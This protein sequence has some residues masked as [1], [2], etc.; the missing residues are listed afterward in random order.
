MNIQSIRNK[1]DDIKCFLL[2]N[3]CDVLALSETWINKD[4]AFLYDIDNFTAV[5]SCREGRGGGTSLY[6]KKTIKC[7]EVDSFGAEKTPNW[8]CV[9]IGESDLK[10]SVVYKPPS[11][12]NVEFLRDLEIILTKYPRKHVVVGDININLLEDCTLVTNYKNLL[13]INNFKINN[14]ITNEN[15]TRVTVNNQSIIDHVLSDLGSKIVTEDVKICYNSL[16]DHNRLS[17]KINYNRKIY[18]PKVNHQIKWIDYKKFVYKFRQNSRRVIVSSFGDLTELIQVAKNESQ[19]IKTVKIKENNTWINGEI[20]EMMRQRDDAYKKKVKNPGNLLY[21]DEFRKIKN[22]VNNKIR[23]L[24]NHFFRKEWDRAGTDQRKQWKFINGFFNNK[25]N[26]THID[27]LNINGKII[28]EQKDIVDQLNLHFSQVGENIVNELNNENQILNDDISFDEISCSNTLINVEPTNPNEVCK[29]LLELKRNSSPGEDEV[30]VLDL[31]NLKDHVT[32]IISKL[33]NNVF[34]TG[35]FPPELKKNKITP[36]FKSGKK[37]QMNNYRPITVV[38]TLSKVLERVIKERLMSFIDEN[39]L[40]DQYQYGFVKSSSTLAATVDFI[41]TISKALDEGKI[42]VV[43]FIDLK[44]A[45]DVVSH[46]LLLRK[47]QDLGLGPLFLKLLNTYLVDRKQFVS[48]SGISS[49]VLINNYGVPQGSVLGP[50]FYAL[51]VLS[52]KSAKLRARYFTFA[53][54]TA[55]I[56]IGDN[57]QELVKIINDDLNLYY[58]WLIFNR[59]KLN[60]GKT[61]FML[62]KQKNKRVGDMNIKINNVNL[63][64]ASSVKYLGLVIDESLNW[65]M[66]INKI[67]QKIHSLIP[68]IYKSRSYLT[69]KTKMNVYNAFFVSHIRY[70]LPIWGTCCKTKFSEVQVTQN[71]VLKIMFN[72]NI[73]TH[74]ETL[75]SELDVFNLEGLLLLEQCKL[76]YKILNKQLKCNSSVVS[77][78]E[79][80]SYNT[81]TQF[82]LYVLY[83]RTN[84]GMNSPIDC[85]SRA[86]NA[87]PNNLKNIQ[88]FRTFVNKLK[89]FLSMK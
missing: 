15:A 12:S 35:V 45:F 61:Q 16:S 73:A 37:D 87:L 77:S 27:S 9:N 48:L 50:L 7:Q 29:I 46:D 58:K 66:H 84:I 89:C 69:H 82:N 18:K 10:L 22:K 60:T 33:I 72:Y 39:S 30:T 36:I 6:I 83:S 47:L 53:D 31:I 5:H 4:E 74:T 64:R 40:L 2:N 57:E 21:N 49:E 41:S 38:N 70:L 8:T 1:V 17:F 63:E 19:N 28:E 51:Y 85:A 52:L 56:Y 25:S 14:T 34:T 59:L 65:Q 42:V 32:G 79:I 44:K 55:Q 43:V 23:T 86:Y 62:F 26:N 67:T 13:T 20:L 80:H 76:I 81:R 78:N 3:S 24:K 54:D 88:L 75:Y 68:C 11:Y 71:K